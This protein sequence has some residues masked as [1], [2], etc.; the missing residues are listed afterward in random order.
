[1]N[2][3][4]AKLTECLPRPS[5]GSRRIERRREG[6]R[7][8]AI[9]ILVN[10]GAV[11]GSERLVIPGFEMLGMAARRPS[12]FG[13][14]PLTPLI[15]GC[16]PQP[17]VQES[18]S[19]AVR[20]LVRRTEDLKA[21]LATSL[22]APVS[23]ATALTTSFGFRATPPLRITPGG[24]TWVICHARR[25]ACGIPGRSVGAEADPGVGRYLD[26]QPVP[27]DTCDGRP[28]IPPQKN[29]KKLCPNSDSNRGPY[30]NLYQ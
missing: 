29:T 27:R 19:S 22:S 6:L 13:R 1:M 28:K 16:V 12:S 11:T 30:H 23:S 2:G 3:G 10:A 15:L 5:E 21:D 24:G 4:D 7:Y 8:A 17:P 25:S 26:F 14:L 20:G 18:M 9:N